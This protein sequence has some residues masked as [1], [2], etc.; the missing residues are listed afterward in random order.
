LCSCLVKKKYYCNWNEIVAWKF[1]ATQLEELKT[2]TILKVFVNLVTSVEKSI[3]FFRLNELS[4]RKHRCLTLF[5]KKDAEK[6]NVCL[7]EYFWILSCQISCN[8]RIFN[9]EGF[10]LWEDISHDL[11]NY[12]NPKKLRLKIRNLNFYTLS[13]KSTLESSLYHWSR[14]YLKQNNI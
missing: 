7:L 4:S 2:D 6:L 12:L 9:T 13:N 1:R 5:K 3:V 10:W 8:W 11:T 14:I